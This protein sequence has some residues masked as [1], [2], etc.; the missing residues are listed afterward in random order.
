M[1]FQINLEQYYENIAKNEKKDVILLLDRGLLDFTA[2]A[3]D[4]NKEKLFQMPGLAKETM[5][6]RYDLVMHLVTAANGALKYYTLE[7][8]QARTETPEQAIE[9]DRKLMDVWN[10]SQNHV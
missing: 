8:N 6:D 4:E 5:R 7:N 10:G 3:S 9:I 2:Y 1:R